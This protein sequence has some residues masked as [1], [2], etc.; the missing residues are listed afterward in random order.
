MDVTSSPSISRRLSTRGGRPQTAP[1]GPRTR[2]ISR[3]S[4]LPSDVQSTASQSP[5]ESTLY[6]PGASPRYSAPSE[7]SA[8]HSDS[9]AL[10]AIT[11]REYDSPPAPANPPAPPPP[12]PPPPQQ[13]PEAPDEPLNIK[14]V[15]KV[16]A[17]TPPKNVSFE[18]SPVKW[19]GLPLEAALWTFN[20]RELQELVSRAIRSSSRESFIRVLSVENLDQSLPTE[21]E[22]LNALKSV[23]Q[24]KYRFTVHRR[25]MLLQALHSFSGYN[26]REKDAELVAKLTSQLSQTAAECDQLLEDLLQIADQVGQITRLLDVHWAS[27]LAI[28]LRKLNSSYGR[29]T[30]DLLSARA[31][32]AT[33]EAELNDAWQQAEK[34]AREMDEADAEAPSDEDEGDAVIEVAEVISL[35]HRKSP[36]A[37]SEMVL[38]S[39]MSIDAISR[40]YSEQSQ[41]ADPPATTE[42]VQAPGESQAAEESHAELQ[43]AS[44]SQTKLPSPSP[45]EAGLD[46]AVPVA[47]TSPYTTPT[48]PQAVEPAA[49][50]SDAASIHSARSVRSA[51]SAR[52]IRSAKSGRTTRTTDTTRVDSVSAARRRSLR[53]SMGSLRMPSTKTRK[54]SHPPVPSLPTISPAASPIAAPERTSTA[55]SFLDFSRDTSESDTDDADVLVP[56]RTSIDDI[57]VV[58]RTP[59]VAI[60]TRDDIHVM[61]SRS[62]AENDL[63]TPLRS[64]FSLDHQHPF[65]N[66]EPMNPSIP[67]IWLLQDAPK[68]PAE[69]VES[70]MRD[71]GA[72]HTKMGSFQRLKSL[73]KRYSLPFP[74]VRP[75][76]ARNTTN[77]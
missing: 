25:T 74:P 47:S 34:L 38:R 45:S 65:A 14:S 8:D 30:S 72:G 44:P 76:P 22:R 6:S 9:K 37:S 2:N 77:S 69:R 13:A 46:T 35:N 39:V 23:T 4:L 62:A 50:T 36:S 51:R 49:E 3:N 10:A 28:A 64:Q 33:L 24:S 41:A 31:R 29:R 61:P 71:R 67:S 73:T 55:D 60:H 70:M 1:M 53:T 7:S 48:S 63:V 75:K 40:M 20:S 27:A 19:K 18:P 58:A 66:E 43:P 15:P 5:R 11:E 57:E 42:E 16:A 32:I 26:D 54:G 12:P 52:S 17:L 59:A 56:R 21:L 68:T